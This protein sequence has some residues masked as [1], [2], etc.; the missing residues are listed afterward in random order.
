MSRARRPTPLRVPSIWFFG[1]PVPVRHPADEP[2]PDDCEHA[3]ACATDE[4]VAMRKSGV[5]NTIDS[6]SRGLCDAQ[7]GAVSP[8]S[9]GEPGRAGG[10]GQAPLEADHG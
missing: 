2:L 4:T 5:R 10:L 1:E 3:V 8:V 9:E 6:S 7:P